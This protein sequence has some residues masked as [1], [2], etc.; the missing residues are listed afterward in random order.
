MVGVTIIDCLSDILSYIRI[1]LILL[2]SQL[3]LC[4]IYIRLF[5]MLSGNYSSNEI[6]FFLRILVERNFCFHM[7]ISLRWGGRGFP[8]RGF[9]ICLCFSQVFPIYS[10]IFGYFPFVIGYSAIDLST[11]RQTSPYPQH[12][13]NAIGEGSSRVMFR[14]LV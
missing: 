5:L 13:R 4:P 7:G 10:L 14:L 6:I 3:F 9:P 8:I 1:P 2:V 12:H 11:Q